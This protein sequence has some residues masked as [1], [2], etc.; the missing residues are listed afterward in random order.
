MAPGGSQFDE[1]FS[2]QT[3]LSEMKQ[4]QNN[5]LDALG[6]KIDL[7]MSRQALHETRIT[8]LERFRANNV[9]AAW[10]ALGA[11]AIF[12]FDLVKYHLLTSPIK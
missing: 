7:A 8:L 6:D 1:G 12:L 4:E 11:F 2:L 10:L 3:F 5:K 9:K